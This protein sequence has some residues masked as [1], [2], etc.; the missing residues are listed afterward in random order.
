AVPQS[1][2]SKKLE[3]SI[4]HISV[5]MKLLIKKKVLVT[6]PM[7]GKCK[8]YRLNNNYAWKGAV[9]NMHNY[10]TKNKSIR[11]KK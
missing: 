10:K 4:P 1:L 5:C 9:K 2:I 8:S 3:Y 6:G 11:K 7:M